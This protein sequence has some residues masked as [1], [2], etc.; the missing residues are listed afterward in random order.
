MRRR[1]WHKLQGVN[2]NSSVPIQG[3]DQPEQFILFCKGCQPDEVVIPVTVLI[4]LLNI[5][6]IQS[7]L[8]GKPL[9][10]VL[11][12]VVI[13]NDPEQILLTGL[14]GLLKTGGLENPQLTGQLILIPADIGVKDLVR[15]LQEAKTVAQ[16]TV[17][18]YEHGVRQVLRWL[19]VPANAQTLPGTFEDH[20]V[21]LITG[22]L[23]GL[24]LLFA[25]YIIPQTRDA[26]V[27]LTRL[28]PLNS[29]KHVR[30]YE[31]T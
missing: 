14:L 19:E 2:S 10:K 5:K 17:I 31:I 18:R 25:K 13:A 29:E 30:L 23:G 21:Y 24:G 7:I 6:R 22:G 8:S 20:G 26:R 11:V 16:D 9:G 3:R 28:S 4:S 15:R 12:Q 1:N 27:V